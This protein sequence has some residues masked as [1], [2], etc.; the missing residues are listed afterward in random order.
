MF[1]EDGNAKQ[2]SIPL[3][4]N[5]VKTLVFTGDKNSLTATGKKSSTKGV[6][7]KDVQNLIYLILKEL[8]GTCIQYKFSKKQKP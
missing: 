6:Y 5:D 8:V 2:L 1:L 3:Y 7:H 4:I